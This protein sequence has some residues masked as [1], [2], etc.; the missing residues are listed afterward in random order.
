MAVGVR[1][2]SAFVPWLRLTRAGDARVRSLAGWDEDALTLAVEAALPLAEQHRAA[3]GALS[4]VFF[5]S[6]SAPYTETSCASLLASACD[7]PP[8]RLRTTDLGA[9]RRAGVQAMLAALER[10]LADRESADALVTAAHARMPQ[11]SDL[12]ESPGDAAAA[13]ILG[14]ASLAAEL[15]GTRSVAADVVDILQTGGDPVLRPGEAAAF[16]PVTRAAIAGA[17]TNANVQ[18]ADVAGFAIGAPSTAAAKELMKA[19][20]ADPTRLAPLF[21]QVIG[22]TGA[23]QPLLSFAAALEAAKAGDVLVLAAWG[24]GADALV[25]RVVASAPRSARPLR[26][27]LESSRRI[28]DY[29]EYRHL[30]ARASGAAHDPAHAGNMRLRGA[31]CR[32]CGAVRFPPSPACDACRKEGADSVRLS[33]RGTIAELTR[34][35]AA[36]TGLVDLDG[37]GRVSV[38]LTDVDEV[39]AG[40]PVE[41]T[42]RYGHGFRYTWKARPVRA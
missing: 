14:R 28:G 16:V 7:V 40:M 29:T 17:L 41:L 19:S 15:L 36:V 18:I 12:S 22:H 34:H 32:H 13:V 21:D 42:L 35:E 8:E 23:A 10:L 6:T 26:A 5:A 3:S 38:P 9:S 27:L 31:K 25:F 37:G 4:G 30:V 20:G 33:R 1:A 11:P 24:D 2:F 39:A